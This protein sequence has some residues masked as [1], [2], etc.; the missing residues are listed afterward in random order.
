MRSELLYRSIADRL[1][2]QIDQGVL[3]PGD[4]MPS[5]RSLQHREQCSL[6]TVLEAYHLLEQDGWIEARPQSGHFVLARSSPTVRLVSEVSID[7]RIS[8]ILKDLGDPRMISFGAAVPSDS[9]LPLAQI[10]RSLARQN[11]AEDSHRYED[12]RA[13]PLCAASWPCCTQAASASTT[14]T[15][16]SSQTDAARRSLYR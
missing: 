12:P 14:K 8:Q 16:S 6:S 7:G 15:T 4:R 3:R 2:L 10:S 5:L 13:I 1:K 11:R 9:F